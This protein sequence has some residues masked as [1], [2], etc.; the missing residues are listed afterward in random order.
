MTI[1]PDEVSEHSVVVPDRIFKSLLRGSLTRSV[2]A[3]RSPRFMETKDLNFE[4]NSFY[5]LPV[6]SVLQPTP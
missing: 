4:F 5:F 2:S 1:S 6:S 3:V